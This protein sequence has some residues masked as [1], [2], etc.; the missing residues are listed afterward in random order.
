M[1]VMCGANNDHRLLREEFVVSSK[2]C[3]T[4]LEDLNQKLI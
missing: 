3:Q 2:R 1:S 4:V